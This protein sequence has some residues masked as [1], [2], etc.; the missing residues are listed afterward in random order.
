MALKDLFRSSSRASSASREPTVAAPGAGRP[1]PS[2]LA[3]ERMVTITTSDELAAYLRAGG[4][5]GAPLSTDSAMRLATVWR[6]NAIISGAIATLPFGPFRRLGPKTREPADDHWLWPLLK[7]RPNRRHKPNEFKRMLQTHLL[8]RGN[9]YVF[10]VMNAR[11]QVVE[12]LALDPDRM[13]VEEDPQSLALRYRYRRKGG[14]ETIFRAAE[15]IHLRGLT[16][17]GVVGVS[18]FEYAKNAMGLAKTTEEH[19]NAIFKNGT[20][21]GGVMRHPSQLSTPAYER[22]EQSLEAYSGPEN[23]GKWLVLEEGAE[24]TPVGMT[25]E[26]AQFLETRKFQRNEIAM[27]FGVPPHMIGDTE[28]STSWGSG[29]EQQGIGFVTYTLED[30]LTTWEEAFNCDV[31]ADE[32]DVYTRFNRSALVRGDLKTRWEAYVKALQWGVYSPDEVRA[33]EDMNPREDGQGG[34]YYPPPNTAGGAAPAED[35]TGPA[36]NEESDE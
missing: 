35:G 31:L 3:A 20:R 18:V 4:N 32:P 21:L 25:S 24:V 26:D 30:W 5:G 19:G 17:D 16:L 28:K 6:C 15:I 13:S 23:A 10:K 27:F 2:V 34:I 11:R 9:A 36:D 22:L 7:R 14:G 29:I 33:L 8:F 12:L 1:A